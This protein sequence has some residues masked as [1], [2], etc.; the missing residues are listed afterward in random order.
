M[1]PQSSV[2]QTEALPLAG[3][4][5][6]TIRQGNVG[7]Q[8][9]HP[10]FRPKVHLQP[11]EQLLDLA[12]LREIVSCRNIAIESANPHFS[13]AIKKKAASDGIIVV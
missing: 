7:L 8:A 3:V 9:Q 10:R 13:P 12:C 11:E 1:R 5:V 4:I 6:L 2:L